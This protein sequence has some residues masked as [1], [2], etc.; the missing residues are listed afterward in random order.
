MLKKRAAVYTRVSTDKEEQKTSIENQTNSYINFCKRNGYELVHIYVDPGLSATSPNRKEFLEMLY[1]AG[2]DLIEG[3]KG[4]NLYF[5]PSTRKPKF[6][7]I[8]TKDVT[9][10]ARNQN[11]IDIAKKL[12]LNGVHII[13]ENSSLTTLKENW[14]FEF[15][16]YLN[17]A[18]QESRDKSQK[19]SAAY[20]QRAKQGKFHMS[21]ILFG[22]K[23]DENTNE[24]IINNEEA[25][26]VREMFDLYVNH[27]KGVKLIAKYLNEKGITTRRGN[28]W[29]GEAVKR[30]LKNEKYFGQVVLRKKTKQDITS[31]AKVITRD[32]SEW[33]I[34]E[35]AL[36][37]IIDKETW[38][39]AQLLLKERVKQ[40]KKGSLKGLRKYNN[41]FYG[42]IICSKCLSTFTRVT[43]TKVKNGKK[44]IESTYYCR[45]R[46]IYGNCDMRGVSQ[47]VLER[48]ISKIA[49]EKFHESFSIKFENEKKAAKMIV[50]KLNQKLLDIQNEKREITE[51]I[52]EIDSN[53][54]KIVDTF[55]MKDI[56]ENVLDVMSR[57]IDDLKEQ[58]NKLEIELVNLDPIKIEQD[59]DNVYV[60]LN[61]IEKI[62]KKKSYTF[63]EMMKLIDK[64]Y[65]IEGKKLIFDIKVPSL[66]AYY[67]SETLHESAQNFQIEVNY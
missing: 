41:A 40:T 52:K 13:F 45:N 36:P 43:G 7:F 9:R 51:S 66:I 28:L 10:F 22:Y 23:V 63:E 21:V 48:E 55:L 26:V 62:N 64:I 34:L 46:R 49:T 24:Y 56:S 44:I 16:L 39:K 61:E 33:T 18:E 31:T 4:K 50:E 57:K 59:K 17:F 32:E 38:E 65:V 37:A 30:L 15:G 35:N 67:Q 2:L 60:K 8:I 19:V 25:E 14:Q 58:K 54:D 20:R 1:D 6:D 27:N 29:E 3:S 11:S 12:V 47:N 53:I 5:E 42:K